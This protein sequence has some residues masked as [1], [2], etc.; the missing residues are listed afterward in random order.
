MSKALRKNPRL[1]VLT[2]LLSIFS[3]LYA[4]AGKKTAPEHSVSFETVA[5]PADVKPAQPVTA[6]R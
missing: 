5:K 2:V 6:A 1:A 3:S 4:C